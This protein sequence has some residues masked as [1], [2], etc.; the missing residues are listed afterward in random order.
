MAE[1]ENILLSLDEQISFVNTQLKR[2]KKDIDNSI[3][4]SVKDLADYHRFTESLLY[5][6]KSKKLMTKL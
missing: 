2:L 5:L 1:K 3:S 6:V 4:I